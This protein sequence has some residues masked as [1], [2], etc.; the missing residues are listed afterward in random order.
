VHPAGRRTGEA[1]PRA[2]VSAGRGS[3][4][5]LGGGAV[6]RARVDARGGGEVED[7]VLVGE[8][9]CGLARVRFA[10]VD[11][12]AVAEAER[13]LHAVVARPRPR[14][15]LADPV[16][17][18]VLHVAQR[19]GDVDEPRQER[20]PRFP[21]RAHLSA[22]AITFQLEHERAIQRWARWAREQTE[23]WRDADDPGSW[24]VAAALHEILEPARR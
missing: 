10:V 19:G 8:L 14:V 5:R 7:V 23:G 15:V 2:R 21:R 22:V 24:D 16:G 6:D 3:R 9:A 13:A 12:N 17:G 18:E 11:Q 20:R 1:A 4:A